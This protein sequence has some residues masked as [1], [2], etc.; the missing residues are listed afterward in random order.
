MHE[1]HPKHRRHDQRQRDGRRHADKIADAGQSG[2]FGEKRS[3]TGDEEGRDG[4]PRPAPAEVTLDQFR[5]ASAG[6]GAKTNRQFLHDIEDGDQDELQEEEAIAPLGAALGSR[7]DAA[8]VGVGQHDD[9]P[10]SS[11]H[12]ETAPTEGSGSR[13]VG[14]Q[15]TKPQRLI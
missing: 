5:M 7:D 8:R 4:Q 10:G 6:H 9:E 12:E 11:D 1:R 14:G 13:G 3:K 15:W 2:E